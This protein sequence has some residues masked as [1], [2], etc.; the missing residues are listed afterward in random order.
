VKQL[1][2]G[3]E[4]MR[5]D[6]WEDLK[7]NYHYSIQE[8]QIPEIESRVSERMEAKYYTKGDPSAEIQIVRHNQNGSLIHLEEVLKLVYFVYDDIP[9]KI[10][11]ELEK[12][13]YYG[14]PD[15]LDHG[16]RIAGEAG[17]ISTFS[18]TRYSFLRKCCRH[19]H[20]SEVDILDWKYI[21]SPYR[22][23]EKILLL[24][25]KPPIQDIIQEK[26][27]SIDEVVGV[28]SD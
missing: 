20:K 18:D 23:S 3:I 25:F 24:E 14:K 19:I 28:H 11:D 4:N 8:R 10:I 1:P 27:D 5:I 26:L 6:I 22:C 9:D 7:E 2:T 12:D 13:F 21:H 17:Y 15:L 16:K